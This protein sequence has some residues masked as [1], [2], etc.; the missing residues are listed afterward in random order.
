MTGKVIL[1]LS[2]IS[3]LLTSNMPMIDNKVDETAIASQTKTSL[4]S[5]TRAIL[6]P[7]TTHSY[8]YTFG[9]NYTEIGNWTYFYTS[10]PAQK[11][12]EVDTVQYSASFSH[13]LSGSLAVQIRERVQGSL[14]YSFGVS[15]TFSVSR[16]SAA[17]EVGQYIKAYYAR[18]YD[19]TPVYQVDDQHTTGWQ[20]V[21]GSGGKYEYVDYYNTERT[22]AYAKRAIMPQ[23]KLEYYSGSNSTSYNL[24]GVDEVNGGIINDCIKTEIYEYIDGNYQLIRTI[25]G[26]IN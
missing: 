24:N 13:T 9:T 3:V 22:T 12:G 11:E 2:L 4:T 17:L 21:P 6:T 1:G 18:A 20:L 16:S 23:I 14:G 15:E 10:S 19:V 25:N 7:Q 26:A 8:S 5:Q